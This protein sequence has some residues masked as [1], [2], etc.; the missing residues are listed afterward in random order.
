MESR[1]AS[2]VGAVLA[3]LGVSGG[4]YGSATVIGKS[5]VEMRRAERVVSVRGLSE[6]DVEADVASWR[7]PFRG[8]GKTQAEAVAE[9]AKAR[10]AIEE[11]IRTGGLAEAEY[12]FEPF[13]LRVERVTIMR[14]GE[15][16]DEPRYYA[17]SAARLRT[18]NVGLIDKLAG[19]TQGL[20]DKGV[21]LG[22]N[23]YAEVPRPLYAFRGVSKLK[24]EMVA[25]AT[26]AAR[27]AA[28]SFAADSGATVGG[29]ARAEQGVVQITSRDG[30]GFDEAFERYKRM[31][32][33]TSITYYLD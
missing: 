29:I 4:L 23:D 16:V 33:V 1:M 14:D 28:Q 8:V 2:L 30:E 25:E 32:I 7:L 10:K 24:P 15:Q 6:R 12:H 9:A 20:L 13:S 11:F 27:A 18:E 22:D 26:K 31:R 3:A 19:S 5:L 21:Q 17:T